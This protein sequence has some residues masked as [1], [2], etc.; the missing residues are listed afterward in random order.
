MRICL[1][2]GAYPTPEQPF[3]AF[4]EAI[5]KEFTKKGHDVVVIVPQSV[6]KVLFR[7]SRVLSYCTEYEFEKNKRQ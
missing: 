2:A 3:A 4:I 7:K 1:S 6:T 5:A